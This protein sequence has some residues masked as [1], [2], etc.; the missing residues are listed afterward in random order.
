MLRKSQK[1]SSSTSYNTQQALLTTN[2]NLLSRVSAMR[3]STQAAQRQVE[4]EAFKSI[5]PLNQL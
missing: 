1:I 3:E 4:I 2:K 5:E